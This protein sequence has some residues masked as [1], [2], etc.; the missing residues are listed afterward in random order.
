MQDFCK[1]TSF[2]EIKIITWYK[3]MFY[4]SSKISY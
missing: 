2:F 1:N 4:F 3:I